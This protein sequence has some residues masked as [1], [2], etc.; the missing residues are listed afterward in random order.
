[1][2]NNIVKQKTKFSLTDLFKKFPIK[3]GETTYEL[4][5][6]LGSIAYL[7]E[8]GI[9]I[10]PEPLKKMFQEKPVFIL[11]NVLYAGLPTR[12]RQEMSFEDFLDSIN[13]KEMNELHEYMMTALKAI[14][15]SITE[16]E[17]EKESGEKETGSENNESVEKKN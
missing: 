3:I 9:P 6:S 5:Y 12:I 14:G 7:E 4:K 16:I 10:N 1:M 13:E 8:K 17:A 2:E 15:F 11:S